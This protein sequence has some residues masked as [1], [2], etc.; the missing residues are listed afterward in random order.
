ML[1]DDQFLAVF[2]IITDEIG[3]TK[4]ELYDTDDFSVLRLDDVLSKSITERMKEHLKLDLPSTLFQTNSSAT[5]VRDYLKKQDED[6][7][8]D[9]G[10]PLPASRS[11]KP[12]NRKDRTTKSSAP[13]LSITLQGHPSTAHKTI[14]LLPDGSGSAMVYS[15][16]PQIAESVCLVAFNSP[17]LTVQTH[18]NS[19]GEDPISFKKTSIESLCLIWAEEI[20]RRQASGPYILGGYSAGGYYAFEVAKHLRR[21]GQ[22]VE[23]LVLIDSPCRLEF[24]AP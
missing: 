24:G 11:V 17:F 12:N 4:D 23:K 21:A 19:N 14:F 1:N 8:Q 13:P 22:V 3:V 15:Q 16:F 20:Q 9:V 6:R 2:D 7:V 18:N 5:E 10:L